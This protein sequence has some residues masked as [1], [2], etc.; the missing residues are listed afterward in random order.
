MLV[1]RQV[2]VVHGDVDAE[3]VKW[4]IEGFTAVGDTP[5]GYHIADTSGDPDRFQRCLQTSLARVR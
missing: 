5:I 1:P 2:F 3:L 4:T